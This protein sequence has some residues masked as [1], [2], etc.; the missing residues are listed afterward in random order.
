[1]KKPTCQGSKGKL[2]AHQRPVVVQRT[3]KKEPYKGSLSIGGLRMYVR[4]QIA[5]KQLPTSI[6]QTSMW[7]YRDDQSRYLSIKRRGSDSYTAQVSRDKSRRL[8][9]AEVM[10]QI[11]SHFRRTGELPKRTG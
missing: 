3:G 7:F 6:G 9:G 8:G 1:M 11:I 5:P 10:Q 4:D 2:A